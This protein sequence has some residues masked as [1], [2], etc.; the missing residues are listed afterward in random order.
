MIASLPIG[1][2][3]AARALSAFALALCL[4]L[5]AAPF[6]APAPAVAQALTGVEVG[7]GPIDIE[8]DELE[9]FDE[10]SRAIFRGNVR[11]LR[12]ETTLTASALTVFYTAR[13]GN[14]EATPGGAGQDIERIEAQGPVTVST[15]E[16]TAQGAE[17]TYDVTTETI[18]LTGDVVP[19]PTQNYIMALDLG[20]TGNRAIVFDHDGAIAGQ[21]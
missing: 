2:P 18:T 10:E 20:T 13:G 16:Q 9:V 1:R 17:G 15:P 5:G 3:H 6:M 19:M 8:A 4:G 21:A 14:A 12:G 11:V 7:E